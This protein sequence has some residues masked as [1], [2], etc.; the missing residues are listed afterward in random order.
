M[1]QC[2]KQGVG[3]GLVNACT[4]QVVAPTEH[5]DTHGIL[6]RRGLCN[7]ARQN[8]LTSI[9]ED[10]FGAFCAVHSGPWWRSPIL[11][12]TAQLQAQRTQ[13][14]SPR[15]LSWLQLADK[16]WRQ[17]LCSQ[18]AEAFNSI[19]MEP[20]RHRAL[21]LSWART[22][23]HRQVWWQKWSITLMQSKHEIGIGRLPA[24][25]PGHELTR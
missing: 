4:S 20:N 1:L 16:L 6:Q 5:A 23:S 9:H 15:S 22:H 24:V 13:Q 19:L 3:W 10:P 2:V 11:V 18:A 21:G 8:W 12:V 7:Q 25:M 17:E 14:G